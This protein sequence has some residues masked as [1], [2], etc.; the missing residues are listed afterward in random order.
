LGHDFQKEMANRH[1]YYQRMFEA[2]A[3]GIVCYR[4]STK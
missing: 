3:L 2:V 1:P 4:K